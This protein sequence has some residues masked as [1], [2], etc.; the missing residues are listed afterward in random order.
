MALL[1]VLIAF[2]ARSEGAA[3]TP[4]AQEGGGTPPDISAMSPKE[5]FDRLYNRVMRASET[6][7]EATV[8]QFLPMASAAY[9][10]LDSV[11]ADARYHMAMLQLHTDQVPAA[12]RQADSLLA[13]APGHLF[14]YMIQGTVARWQKDDAALRAAHRAFLLHYETEAK[15]R[16]PEYTEHERAV[17]DF[18]LAAQGTPRPRS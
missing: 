16:R 17:S 3:A 8:S 5:R 12:A 18:R 13:A 9:A 6:G 2:L 10:Q 11:D 15:T 1:G 4:P 7:D 14:G